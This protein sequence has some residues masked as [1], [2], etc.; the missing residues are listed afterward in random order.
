MKA[1]TPRVVVFHLRSRQDSGRLA[2]ALR[3]ENP[4]KAR[5]L[6]FRRRHNSA[7]VEI[8]VTSPS[9]VQGLQK[10]PRA[11][12]RQWLKWLKSADVLIADEIL[13]AKNDQTI[14]GTLLRPKAQGDRRSLWKGRRPQLIGL[15]ATLLS[16]DLPDARSILRL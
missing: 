14:Y 3:F 8:L 2:D 10:K 12:D 11:A 9:W 7:T 1:R 13:G 5:L 15:S 16:R 4:Q 6:D